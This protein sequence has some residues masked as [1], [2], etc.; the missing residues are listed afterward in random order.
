MA[1]D[2]VRIERNVNAKFKSK[3]LAKMVGK[4]ACEYKVGCFQAVF[5]EIKSQNGECG[6]YLEKICV[7][8]WSMAYFSGDMY[9]LLTCNIAET[10]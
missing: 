3:D 10:L 9:N 4:A 8:H 1:C 2:F 6:R 7:G 5:N